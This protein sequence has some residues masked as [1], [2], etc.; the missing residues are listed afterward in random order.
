MDKVTI[1]PREVT[2]MYMIKMIRRRRKEIINRVCK[3][4]SKA[5]LLQVCGGP[6]QT[7]RRLQR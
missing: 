4:R 5:A 7:P 1:L 2:K 6:H 3:K